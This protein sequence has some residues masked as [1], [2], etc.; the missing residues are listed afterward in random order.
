[1]ALAPGGTTRAEGN[2][3][4]VTVQV[5]VTLSAASADPVTAQWATIP[6]AADGFAA[7][8][9]DYGA[10]SGTVTFAPGQT[11]RTVALSIKGD[12][13][14]EPDEFVLLGFSDPTNAGIGGLG[15]L[16]IVAIVD[17]DPLPKLTPGAAT[18][19][20]GDSGTVTLQIPVALSAPSG[21]TVSAQWVT[22]APSGAGFA[23]TP[24]DFD[25]ASGAVTFAPGQTARTVEVTV[26]GDGFDESDEFLLVG[27]SN[28]TNATI[29]GLF[30]LGIGGIVDDD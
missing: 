11:S 2:A 6:V 14:D 18:V 25:T 29:G 1:V 30:G 20:E 16:G 27:F 28:P 10:A 7:A 3:G 24:G 21:R 22:A 26:H 4:T 23:S 9:A 5:P 12:A 13:L 17:D 15:G 19:S 8:P